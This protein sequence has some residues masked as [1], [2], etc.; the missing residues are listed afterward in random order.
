MTTNENSVLH[1]KKRINW[2]PGHMVKAQRE[3]QKKIK[4]VD[5]VLEVR[6]ARVALTSGNQ[7][8]HAM[9]GNKPRLV[10][11]NKSNL[12]DPKN[13]A[14]WEFWFTAQK[15]A[16]IFVNSF[17]HRSLKQVTTMAKALLKEKWASFEKKG[18]RPPPLRMMMIGVP[19]TGK[20]TI[21]NRL[22]RRN[23][24]RTGDKP[25]VTQSQEWIVLGKDLE[26]LDTP[27]VMPPRIETEEQGLWLC[28][29][30]AIR[31]EI[32]GK[33]K[34]A[35]FIIGYLLQKK[36]RK[37]FQKYQIERLS[38]D[39]A[40]I[41]ERIG[42]RL[43]FKKQKNQIDYAKTCGQILNDFRKGLLGRHSFESPPITSKLPSISVG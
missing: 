8:L 12:A 40:T 11:L 43:N 28:S 33:E 13:I 37:L 1:H 34:V 7:K 27:G 38:D 22:T 9:L 36:S 24:A 39:D 32:V 6:D 42:E 18:I 35:E 10:I 16:F 29:I 26:L 41:I 15:Q 2:F 19:N 20:S 5:L 4:L 23:A 3:I 25:G 14:L 21:I 30:Y 17:D 31:D